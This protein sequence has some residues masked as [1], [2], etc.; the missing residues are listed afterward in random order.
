MDRHI[1]MTHEIQELLA[2]RQK[3]LLHRAICEGD[4]KAMRKIEAAG[5]AKEALPFQELN[6]L[7]A[8]QVESIL[9]F[10][11]SRETQRAM[12]DATADNHVYAQLGEHR[13][14]GKRKSKNLKKKKVTKSY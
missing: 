4:P 12:E 11:I 10:V 5:S 8:R 14:L 2:D 13:I 1:D 7:G 3:D 9:Q 6:D